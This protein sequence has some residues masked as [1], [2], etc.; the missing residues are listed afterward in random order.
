VG[1]PEAESGEF[2]S[3]KAVAAPTKDYRAP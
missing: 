2:T 3:I 1:R